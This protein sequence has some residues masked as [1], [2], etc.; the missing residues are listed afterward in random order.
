MQSLRDIPG[1]LVLEMEQPPGAK[2]DV[3]SMRGL[4]FIVPGGRF[5]E[6]YYWDSYF[7][8]FGLLDIGRTDPV[9]QI[10]QNFIFQIEH[11]G[12]ILNANRSYYLCRSQPPFLTDLAILVFKATRSDKG[13]VDFLRTT[14][15]AAIKECRQVWMAEPRYDPVTCLSRFRPPGKGVSLEVEEGHFDW[16]L[17]GYAQEH[18]LTIE[19]LISRYNDGRLTEPTLDEFFLDDRAMRESGQ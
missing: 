8:S 14:I 15:L 2:D 1:I 3:M 6:L 7:I 5:N 12:K 9:K 10:I 13:A 16:I 4:E 19:E 18:N 11:Y 17:C